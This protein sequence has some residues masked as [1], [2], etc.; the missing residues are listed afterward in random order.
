RDILTLLSPLSPSS[1]MYPNST[2]NSRRAVGDEK[3]LS[4]DERRLHH[5]HPD[6]RIELNV[7]RRRVQGDI[8]DVVLL[9]HGKFHDLLHWATGPS[10]ITRGGA[11]RH[12]DSDLDGHPIET[13][14]LRLVQSD[15]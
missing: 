9:V 4:S 12:G 5:G 6:V 3:L 11:W 1:S 7:G 15:L 8:Q 10:C 13:L 14:C 2:A